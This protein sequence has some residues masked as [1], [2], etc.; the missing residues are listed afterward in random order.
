MILNDVTTLKFGALTSLISAICLRSEYR[1]GQGRGSFSPDEGGGSAG[2]VA[3]RAPEVARFN[4]G[5]V[6]ILDIGN[7]RVCR[8]TPMR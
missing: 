7:L 8:D 5:P 2:A 6:G 4:N 3:P 1:R